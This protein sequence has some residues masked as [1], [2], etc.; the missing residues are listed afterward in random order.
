MRCLALVLSLHLGAQGKRPD[1]WFSPDKA[2]HFF[3]SMFLE[4][5]SFSVLRAANTSRSGS[6][7]GATILSAGVG[8]GREIYDYYHPGTPSL[9]DLTWDLAGIATAAIALHQTAP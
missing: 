4:S 8:V 3:M 2:K 5:V 1:P 6:L 9:K 7:A